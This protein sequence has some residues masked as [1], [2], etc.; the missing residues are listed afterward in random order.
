MVHRPRAKATKVIDV[1]KPKPSILG[2]VPF[3]NVVDG[4]AKNPF[5]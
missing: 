3:S 2:L 5:G 1:R 4:L